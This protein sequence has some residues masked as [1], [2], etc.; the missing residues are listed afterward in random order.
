MKGKIQSKRIFIGRIFGKAALKDVIK[1]DLPLKKNTPTSPEVMAKE[2][3]GDLEIQRR[4]WINGIEEYANFS[5]DE[6]VHPFF[7]K[8]TRQEVGYFAYK[9][10]DHHLRQFGA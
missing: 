10:N 9:H 1:N 6:F 3:T 7:G 8:M 2:K 5:Q 4:K